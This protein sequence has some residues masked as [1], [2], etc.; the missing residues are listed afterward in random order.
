MPLFESFR[1]NVPTS[2]YKE[3]FQKCIKTKD[4]N[5]LE[6]ERFWKRGGAVIVN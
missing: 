4:F 3:H 1:S 6:E 2:L 5:S